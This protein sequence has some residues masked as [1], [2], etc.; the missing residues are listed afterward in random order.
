MPLR[1][2]SALLGTAVL[3]LVPA[4]SGCTSGSAPSGSPSG[5]PSPSASASDSAAAERARERL[6]GMSVEE[7]IGQLMVLLAEGTTAEESAG[8][9]S[10][11]N[12][13]GLIYFPENLSGA[14]QIARMSNG[15]QRT[16][17][18]NGAGVPLFLGIDQEQ[19]MVS[20]LPVGTR[21]PDAMAVGA[22]RDTAHA[23]AL[24]GATA[25]ELT[26]LGINLDY[27][28]VADTNTNPD[29]P[30]IGIR[31]F[32]SDPDLVSEM[33]AAEAAAFGAGGV[34]PV[35][36]HFPGHGDTDVD[37]HTGLPVIDKP[38]DEWEKE[39]LPPF[40]AAVESGVDAIMTA[41]VLMP[42]LDDSGEPSTLSPDVIGGV[43]RD[44]LGYDGIVTTDALNMEGVR[45]THSDGEVAVR[46]VLA[47]ADQLL[48]PPDPQAAFDALRNAVRKG[49]IS[50]ERL[51]RSVLR[52]LTAK[53]ERGLFGAEPADAAGAEAAVG[54]QEHRAAARALA[55]DS[56]TL[57]RNKGGVLPL[58][59]DAT[60]SVTGSGAEDIGAGLE[61][62]GYTVTAD[63]ASA[64]AAVV[65]TLS[66]RG[67]AEQ[68]SLVSAARESGTPVVV[69]AQGTPYDI[70]DLGAV[71]G[72]LATY[73]SVDASR[74]AAARVL[75]GEVAPA[76]RLPVGIP[77]TDLDFGD[78]LSY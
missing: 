51:D 53:A 2:L 22:T 29:N 6:S 20:R 66:A 78:G 42:A 36:K 33:A 28:P 12:P 77:G 27:A 25:E 7:K 74:S 14:E 48:M 9:V 54:T 52:I 44:E 43:L 62:L 50:T 34:V 5:S 45:Q 75:A 15:L 11:Y 67:D 18:D 64:D 30:V 72:Y 56:A 24:A 38:R 65:G 13:G 10:A 21:F 61:E 41:H 1:R 16:A 68:L 76:G 35:V 73:S 32:G 8:L 57:L 47:G 26:A 40:R 60:V 39:D 4:M 37:S 70:T 59:A 69:V 31:S 19:G 17:A 23:E 63:P 58:D 55:E 46:A 71:D 49:R 3:A